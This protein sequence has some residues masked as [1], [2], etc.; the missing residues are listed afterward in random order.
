MKRADNSSRIHTFY[1][2]T[3]LLAH[4]HKIYI[5]PI[6]PCTKETYTSI[7]QRALAKSNTLKPSRDHRFT[8]T[9]HSFYLHQHFLYMS[10]CYQALISPPFFNP[11]PKYS[12]RPSYESF[13]LF[14][15]PIP[16]STTSIVSTTL[17]HTHAH[18][19]HHLLLNQ[20]KPT[21]CPHTHSQ[22][23]M[24]MRA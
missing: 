3:D 6:S 1:C 20:R 2:T 14:Y 22:A 8:P 15:H 13:R 23:R 18:H 7:T 19:H 9:W 4:T 21:R 24:H 11:P 5:I 17:P 12:T 10:A 16:I